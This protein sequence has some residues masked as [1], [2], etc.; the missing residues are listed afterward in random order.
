M[1]REVS[2]GGW[3]GDPEGRRCVCGGCEAVEVG[4]RLFG[5]DDEGRSFL[6]SL[7]QNS[8]KKNRNQLVRRG[9]DWGPKIDIGRVVK[10]HPSTK[11]T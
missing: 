7:N 2:D 4:G 5:G 9:E 3:E 1:E 8:K 10:I 11:G 6:K